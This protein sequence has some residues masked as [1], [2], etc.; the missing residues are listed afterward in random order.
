MPLI[1]VSETDLHEDSIKGRL[2]GLCLNRYPLSAY[3]RHFSNLG[4][5]SVCNK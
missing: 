3:V 1:C 4:F 2:E 5:Q